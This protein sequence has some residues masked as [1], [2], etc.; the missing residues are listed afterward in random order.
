MS[1]VVLSVDDVKALLINHG[2]IIMSDHCTYWDQDPRLSHQ[3]HQRVQAWGCCIIPVLDFMRFNF[4]SH[5]LAQRSSPFM[6]I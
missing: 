2:L 5:D 3:R 4:G 1:C 6:P